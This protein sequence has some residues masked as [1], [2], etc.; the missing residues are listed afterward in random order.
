MTFRFAD[1][2]T[3]GVGGGA[4]RVFDIT[5]PAEALEALGEVDGVHDEFVVLGGGSNLVVADEGFEG[6]VLR[7]RNEGTDVRVHAEGVLDLHVAAGE[8][9]DDLVARTVES[10]LGGIEALSGV[11]GRV[12]AAVIQNIGAYGHEVG[13]A[14]VSVDFADAATGELRTISA[15]DLGFGY[16]T[17]AFKRGELEG[18][19]TAI[20]LR[21]HGDG[22]SAPVQYAQLA[23]ALG[24]EVGHRA[25]VQQVRDTVLSLRRGKGMV[26]DP[27]DIDSHGCGSFFTN[28]IVH[29]SFAND[30]PTDAPRWPVSEEALNGQSSTGSASAPASDAGDA[31]VAA[32]IPLDRF[33]GDELYAA[34]QQGRQ[35]GRRLVKL[36]AG[37]LIE[38]AGVHRSFALPGSQAGISSRHTLAITNRGG[39]TARQVVELATFVQTRVANE[40]GIALQPEP[41]LLGFGE[42]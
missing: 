34:G 36:S 20:T 24:V 32:V 10:G 2:T 1:E 5:T 42:N 7:V 31:A 6:A 29:A 38:H 13:E 11:P 19:V 39:A 28:P 25:P 37:W 12:G 15:A 18:V 33:R 9:W 21:L 14:L 23:A 22:L 17:S 4:E 16:R 41:I 3:M 26:Y 27:A 8:V 30:L 40:F 35:S